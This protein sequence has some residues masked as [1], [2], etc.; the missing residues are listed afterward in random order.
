[1]LVRT[2]K[3]LK[4]SK[5]L[6]GR[7]LWQDVVPGTSEQRNAYKIASDNARKFSRVFS[8]I[9]TS[10][11]EDPDLQKKISRMWNDGNTF[12]EIMYEIPL[13]S[14][15]DIYYDEYKQEI[16]ERLENAYTSVVEASGKDEMKRLNRVLGT[17]LDFMVGSG[18]SKAKAKELLV[19]VNVYSKKWIEKQSMKLLTEVT[20]SQRKTIQAIFQRSYDRGLHGSAMTRNL[21]DNI[22][23]TDREYKALVRQEIAMIEAQVPTQRR[24]TLLDRS[25]RKKLKNRAERIARTETVAAQSHGRKTAWQLGKESG[26]LPEN[27]EREWISASESDRLCDICEDLDGKKAPLDGTYDSIAGPLQGPPAHVNCRCTETLV[28]I[29]Q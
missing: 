5:R 22:G 14:Q 4:R 15:V 8:S 17:D 21:M 13:F 16:L 11:L 10:T 28:R 19:P 12:L 18:F 23:L 27:I 7:P 6:Q 24:K 29:S 25:R 1:M 26:R 9:V 3:A 20:D 2:H